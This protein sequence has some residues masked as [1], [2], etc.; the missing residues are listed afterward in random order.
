[1]LF[2]MSSSGT[3]DFTISNISA[4]HIGKLIPTLHNLF[5]KIERDTSL[6]IL[7]SQ[8]YVDTQTL[9]DIVKVQNYRLTC[10]INID[11]KFLTKY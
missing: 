3:N 2:K 7:G 8:S 11:R 1:M 6:F 5:H 9:K 10:I 4:K